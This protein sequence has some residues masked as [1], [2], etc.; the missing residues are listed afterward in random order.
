MLAYVFEIAAVSSL[1]HQYSNYVEDGI[2]S[3]SC[4]Y[5]Q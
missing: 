1:V 2:V 3:G 5:V 4:V